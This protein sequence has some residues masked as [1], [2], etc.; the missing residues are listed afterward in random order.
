MS[1]D[2]PVKLS[3]DA[4]SENGTTS[5]GFLGG[6]RALDSLAQFIVAKELLFHPSSAPPMSRSV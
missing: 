4:P 1:V 6:S 3:A 2:G 5:P